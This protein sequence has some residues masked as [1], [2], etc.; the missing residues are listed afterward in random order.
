MLRIEKDHKVGGLTTHVSDR[1]CIW[2]FVSEI[3]NAKGYKKLK[4]YFFFQITN[5]RK[6]MVQADKAIG[7]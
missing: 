5:K 4:V 3:R 1:N 2:L 7:D 6:S